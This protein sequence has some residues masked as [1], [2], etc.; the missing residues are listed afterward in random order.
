MAKVLWITECYPSKE[1]PQYCIFLEQQVKELVRLGHE[2]DVLIPCNG[3]KQNEIDYEIYNGINIYKIGYKTDKYNIFLS[4]GSKYL[5][6]GI[7]NIYRQKKYDIFAV[8]IVSEAVYYTV[9]KVSKKFDIKYLLTFHGLNVY[10][11]YYAKKNLLSK[12]YS[13]RKKFLF[14]KADAIIGVSEKVKNVIESKI[15]NVPVYCIYNG[16]DTDIFSPVVGNNICREKDEI[17]IISVGNLIPIK[18]F[19]Y[20]IDGIDMIV[21]DN[22]KVKLYILGRGKD[23]QDLK[24]QVKKLGLENIVYFVGYK[25]YDIVK[26]Y[27]QNA[28]IFILPSYFEAIGCVYLEAMAS[29][30]ATIGVKGQ[31][32]DEIIIDGENGMLIEPQNVISIYE[33]LK[34]LV[35]DNKLRNQIAKSG[36]NTANNF[37][38]K[39]SAKSLDKVYNEILGM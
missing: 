37:T 12:I 27:M 33:K 2:V 25:P 5:R 38:W 6:E 18:G 8:H 31:G 24:Q 20:L 35:V 22:I 17:I 3:S 34:L 11:D 1:L 26:K 14:S 10:E 29:G 21:R 28:D 39:E 15:N 23:E 19:K 7:E 4:K 13:Y 36:I 30:L 32:I 16:V 9:G